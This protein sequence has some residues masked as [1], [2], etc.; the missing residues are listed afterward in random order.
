MVPGRLGA[1]AEIQERVPGLPGSPG[2]G[3][4]R[5]DARER[6]GPGPDL[7][8]EQDVHAAQ[9]DGA[10][11]QEVARQDAR[12]RRGQELPPG[13]RCPARR[14]PQ[15]GSGQDPAGS[16]PHRSGPPGRPAHLDAPVAPARILPGQLLH[17]LPHLAREGPAS[18]GARGGPSARDQA[19]VPGQQGARSHDPVQ[20]PGTGQ[21]PPQR[22]DH[23]TAGP[24]RLRAGDLTAQHT[25]LMPQ[26]QDLEVLS[27]ICARQ[28]HQPAEHADHEQV[29]K[30]DEHER[31]A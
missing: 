7:H 12:C 20:P 4:V 27:R 23:G 9:D 3:R 29:D 14:G 5:G 17:Q 25:D 21:E 2:S 10:G 1:C 31:R 18:R 19:L 30:A 15:P 11:M 28:E 13:R 26:H 24:I 6:P 8:R 16:S 22:R